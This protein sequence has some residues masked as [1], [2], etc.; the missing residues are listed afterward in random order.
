MA[1][2]RSGP[3]VPETSVLLRGEIWRVV[4]LNQVERLVVVVGHQQLTAARE[5]ALVVDFDQ[6]PV[7][8]TSLLEVPVDDP[9]AGVVRAMTV[10]PLR[11]RWFAERIG[12]MTEDTMEQI[13][14]ALRAAL[15]L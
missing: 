3:A 15:D 5:D 7:P 1:R 8:R 13:D 11:K 9:V 12:R 6:S 10:A 2:H 14:I 4:V